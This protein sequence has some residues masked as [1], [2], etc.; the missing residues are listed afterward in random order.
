M[1]TTP[2]SLKISGH[3]IVVD[4]A[5]EGK[6]G[7]VIGLRRSSR[8]APLKTMPNV[9]A[10]THHK[11]FTGKRKMAVKKKEFVL[12]VSVPFIHRL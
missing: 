9:K 12:S 10:A 5:V 6:E 7:N 3:R 1:G 2:V 11:L 4:S 8:L